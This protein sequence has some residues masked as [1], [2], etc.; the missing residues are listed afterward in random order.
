MATAAELSYYWRQCD[1]AQ[2]MFVGGK[3]EKDRVLRW[4]KYQN[5][6]SGRQRRTSEGI[7]INVT[8]ALIENLVS[9]LLQK[10]PRVTCLPQRPEDYRS[11]RARQHWLNNNIVRMRLFDEAL[12]CLYDTCIF[13]IGYLKVGLTVEAKPPVPLSTPRNPEAPANIATQSGSE[14]A[15]EG[16][17]DL[18]YQRFSPWVQRVDPSTIYVA[19]GC[20]RLD[21]S[22]YVIH[23]LYLPLQELKRR[24]EYQHRDAVRASVRY[25]P[26][27]SIFAPS[28]ESLED[29]RDYVELYEIWDR[30]RQRVVTISPTLRDAALRDIPWP[31]RGLQ[32]FP[33]KALVLN[34]IPREYYGYSMVDLISDHQEEL[35]VLRGFM[36]SHFK[37]AGKICFVDDQVMG[38]EKCQQTARAG[39]WSFIPIPSP[40]GDRQWFWEFPQGTS[41]DPNV[42]S[43]NQVLMEGVRL[44]TGF[45][46]FELG[47]TTKGKSATEASL[48]G[49]ARSSR[50]E[51]KRGIF[52]RFMERTVQ[53]IDAIGRDGVT[54]EQWLWITGP[55]GLHG[56]PF[57]PEDAQA[58]VDVRLEVGST[59]DPLDDPVK[60]KQVLELTTLGLNPTVIQLGGTNVP[61]LLA[62]A[63]RTIGV[64]DPER[65]WP[66][67]K[68]PLN[69]EDENRLLN[70]GMRITRHPLDNDQVH[71]QSHQTGM[72]AADPTTLPYWQQHMLEHQQALM[73]MQQALMT[74]QMETV[75]GGGPPMGLSGGALTPRMGNPGIEGIEGLDGEEGGGQDRGEALREEQQL[76]NV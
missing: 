7:V 35:N 19:P 18:L 71:L 23:K 39:P 22:P 47:A 53:A 26:D 1:T 29:D 67:L 16:E 37:R 52:E 74:G 4:T 41:F 38:K 5:D 57:R 59:V 33:V 24:P 56:L 30:V 48:M 14:R 42:Y 70:L 9:Q 64:P 12:A 13:G 68:E 45:A 11:A 44:I 55:D 62:E 6:F 28:N 43:I 17:P 72:L 50:I 46:D 25:G 49:E 76:S 51:H 8:W 69:P 40:G 66:A 31:Y 15:T 54:E 73:A 3:K 61:A 2:S 65:F 34:P 36:L 75:A 60:K 21:Q 32:D 58:Q 63:A 10:H 27:G 20:T